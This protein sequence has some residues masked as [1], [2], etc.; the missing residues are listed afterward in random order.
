MKRKKTNII[1]VVLIAAAIIGLIAYYLYDVLY[2]KTPYTKNLFR[3]LAIV[4][5]LLGTAVRVFNGG[6]RKNLNM[7]EKAYANEI[8]FAFNN[9]SVQRKKLLCACR[10][11][12]ESNYN[13][14]LK[15]LFQ[16][17]QEC[18]HD[19]DAVPVLLF[20]ALCY[21]D[22][23]YTED[24]IKSYYELLKKDNNHAQAH[25]NLGHLL[26]KSGEFESA[27]KHYN[28]SIEIK[29]ENYF[30]YINRANYYFRINDYDNAITDAKQALQFK[31]NGVEAA[32]LLTI[33]YALKNDEENKKKYYHIAITSGK[34]PEELNEA[35][36]YFLNENNISSKDDVE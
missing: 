19:R 9:N 6:S 35:I 28:K 4:F 24:A 8:G 20:I 34:Q 25:S 22:A 12:D 13:K 5:M 27:L 18:E 7:Y 26:V 15:Y 23:G 3:M 33:I 30:A 36:Q 17:L 29:P 10:L 32:S 11:Y 21:T 16:L 1:I 31:N 14:A 2:I